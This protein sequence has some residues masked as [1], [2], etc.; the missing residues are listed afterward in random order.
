MDATDRST[1][2]NDYAVA[3]E[4][5]DAAIAIIFT[6][7][8]GDSFGMPDNYQIKELNKSY[9]LLVDELQKL[10]DRN[11]AL[12]EIKPE[13]VW[14]RFDVLRTS[15][16]E[17]NDYATEVSADELHAHGARLEKLC[18]VSGINNAILSNDQKKL[19]DNAKKEITKYNKLSDD[20]NKQQKAKKDSEWQISE[21]KLDYKLDGTI[22]INDVL[23]LKKAHA[24]SAT[25]RLIEQSLKNPNNLFIPDLGQTARNISTVLNGAGFTKELRQLFFPT[26]SKNKGVIFRPTISREQADAESIDT[27]E[28]DTKLKELGALTE[29]KT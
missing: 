4:L 22:L 26:V 16:W 25:E 7:I 13:P 20:V 18:I 10:Y 8:V 2:I 29:P 5:N 23:K 3:K 14:K 11:P 1:Q 21:Y 9:I 6:V 24:G 19:L 17:I 15:T 28:L 27:L 12:A